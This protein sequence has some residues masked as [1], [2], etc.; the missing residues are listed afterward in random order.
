METDMGIPGK[1]HA[2]LADNG[3]VILRLAVLHLLMWAAFFPESA[4]HVKESRGPGA[5]E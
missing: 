3:V 5:A 2:A 4:L 1:R